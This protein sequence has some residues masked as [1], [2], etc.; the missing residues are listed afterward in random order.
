ML[1]VSLSATSVV[2]RCMA[3]SYS[4]HFKRGGTYHT[5]ARHCGAAM[6]TAVAAVL[7][8]VDAGMGEAVSFGGVGG[9]L[10]EVMR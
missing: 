1:L 9:G 3:S 6:T 8:C 4:L 10:Q 7:L 5:R 2:C